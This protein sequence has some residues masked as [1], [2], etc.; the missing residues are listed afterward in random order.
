VQAKWNDGF[1]YK[2]QITKVGTET[3]PMFDV[4]YLEYGNNE[5]VAE[6]D[7][8]FAT[9]TEKWEVGDL[10]EARW[11]EDNQ[12]YE[13]VIDSLMPEGFASGIYLPSPTT[14]PSCGR[15]DINSN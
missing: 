9:G 7:I 8:S 14:L 15:A 10:C 5:K 12:W 3:P 2:A 13:A 4:H 6:S 1:W 11:S